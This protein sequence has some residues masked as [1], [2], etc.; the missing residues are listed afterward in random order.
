MFQGLEKAFCAYWYVQINEERD[1][2][3]TRDDLKSTHDLL[4][5]LPTDIDSK[6]LDTARC[7]AVCYTCFYIF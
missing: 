5:L 2:V 7:L 4:R 1:H 3:L 6:V